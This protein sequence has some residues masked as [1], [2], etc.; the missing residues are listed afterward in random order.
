[1]K[2][3]RPPSTEPR[4]YQPTHSE[5]PALYKMLCGH[6]ARQLTCDICE[7]MIE[8]KSGHDW[9]LGGWV[10]DPGSGVSCLSYQPKNVKPLPRNQMRRVLT[11]HDATVP[12][13]CG[14]CAARKGTEASVSLHTRRDF[15]NAVRNQTPFTCHESTGNKTLCGGWCRAVRQ[16]SAAAKGSTENG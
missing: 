12:P 11:Q 16:R 13:V 6:C 9:P 14:G 2:Q 8:M 5:W 15:E 7:G 3:A 4:A 1:M 10:V